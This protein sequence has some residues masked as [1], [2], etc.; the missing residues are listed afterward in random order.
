M[1]IIAISFLGLGFTVGVLFTTLK[2]FETN[3]VITQQTIEEKNDS[4]KVENNDIIN[5]TDNKS[6]RFFFFQE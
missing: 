3:K 1:N 6:D 4:L 2:H 5:G